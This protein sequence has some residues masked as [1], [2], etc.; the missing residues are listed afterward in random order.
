MLK[1]NALHEVVITSVS[2]RASMDVLLIYMAE[3]IA[4]QR[5]ECFN[6]VYEEIKQKQHEQVD[7]VVDN[8]Q[9]YL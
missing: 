2:T 7:A 5:G 6:K 4:H 3:I 1:I 9:K 8:M